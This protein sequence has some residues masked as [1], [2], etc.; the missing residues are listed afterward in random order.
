MH[1]RTH[2]STHTIIRLKLELIDLFWPRRLFYMSFKSH[3]NC[4]HCHIVGHISVYLNVLSLGDV[5]AP[6]QKTNQDTLAPSVAHLNFDNLLMICK[7]C[8]GYLT[9]SWS[10]IQFVLFCFHSIF[11]SHFCECV[12]VLWLLLALSP[13]LYEL[14]YNFYF[15]MPWKNRQKLV[16]LCMIT[17]AETPT[18]SH[19]SF[20]W[21][22][23]I[24]H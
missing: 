2:T 17:L 15:Y 18:I 1:T 13:L 12:C 8:V 22:Q 16:S 19:H 4:T 6:L 11:L 14:K 23:H 21:P 20:D 10:L 9:C 3:L 5:R 24:A 7:S